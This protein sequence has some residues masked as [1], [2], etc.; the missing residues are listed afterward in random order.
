MKKSIY[1]KLS[2]ISAIFLCCSTHLLSQMTSS[3]CLDY[4]NS[5]NYTKIIECTTRIINKN[6]KDVDTPLLF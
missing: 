1:R 4:Y 2:S 6:P 5:Q 3:N